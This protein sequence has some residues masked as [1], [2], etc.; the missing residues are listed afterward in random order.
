MN[1]KLTIVSDGSIRST[2]VTTKY[3]QV[4]S[5]LEIPNSNGDKK[6][7]KVLTTRQNGNIMIGID[8]TDTIA[9]SASNLN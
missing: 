1:P 6:F 4:T 2:S 7:K 5:G 3:D 9:A 8:N